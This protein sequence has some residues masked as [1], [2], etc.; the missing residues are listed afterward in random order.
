MTASRKKFIKHRLTKTKYARILCLLTAVFFIAGTC[1]ITTITFSAD[2]VP[3]LI[4]PIVQFIKLA[5][6]PEPKI[7]TPSNI[8]QQSALTRIKLLIG[9]TRNV[10]TI[11]T[12]NSVIIVSPEIASAQ[13]ENGNVLKITGAKIGETMLIITG[14]GKRQ[15]F[16]IEVFWKP[17]VAPRQNSVHAEQA[18]SENAK[19]SGS[20]N[21]SSTKNSEQHLS[22][23]RNRIEFRRK[24]SDDRTLR[25]SGEMYKFFGGDNREKGLSNFQ[26]YGLDR[27]S[28]SIDSPDKTI[29]FLDSS[30]RISPV[31]SNNFD[32][33][34]FH[35]VSAPKLSKNPDSPRK[36]IEVFAG[37]ARPTSVFYDKTRAKLIGALIPVASGVSWQLRA[38]FVS[39]MASKDNQLGR[40]G[41]TF[42]LGGSYSPNKKFSANGEI[43]LANGSLSWGARFNLKLKKFGALT[44]FSRV[45]KDSPL[46]SLNGL[47]GG[48]KTEAFSVYWRPEKR[49]NFSAR[50][51]HTNIE[52][53]TN[54]RFASFN[55]ST[56][57]ANAS[58]STVRNSRFNFRFTDQQIETAAPGNSSKFQIATKTFT[59]G[60]NTRINRY[61][62]NDFEAGINLSSE[63]NAESRL[64]TGFTVREQLRFTWNENSL[65]GFLNYTNKTSSLTSLIMQNPQLLPLE[66]QPVF[67]LDPTQFLQV[68]RDRLA[69]LLPGIE[70]PATRNMDAGVRFQTTVSRFTLTGETRYGANEVY[71]QNQKNLFT[72]I[73][74]NFLLDAA[75]SIQINGWHSFGANSQSG[76]VFGFT[77]R[78]GSGSGGGFQFSKLLGLNK[79]K[80]RGRVFYDLNGN[81]QDDA[82]E[83]GVIGTNVKLNEKRS[84]KTDA[85]GKYE[86]SANEGRY[87]IS[88]VSEELGV[89]LSASTATDRQVAV[90]SR[91]TV[92]VSFG[93]S[94]FGFISGRVFNDANLTDEPAKSNAK[95]I[96]NVR[97]VLHSR[98][99]QS[100]NSIVERVSIN[101]GHYE[102]RN[103]PPGNYTLSIDSLTLPANFRLPAQ[104]SWEIKVLPLQGVYLDIPIM[105]QRAVAGIVF[106]DKDGDGK[107]NPKKDEPVEGAT[108]TVNDSVAVSD[109]N[110]AYILRNLP[111]GRMQAVARTP[112]GLVNSPIFIDLS[113][114]PVTKR[115][116]D[117][118]VALK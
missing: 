78:F 87:N 101:G 95:G 45:D 59:A 38:G 71:S 18:L 2:K 90:S 12:A 79:G 39:V 16:I 54:S 19:M 49:F 97:L 4:K 8:P 77:H 26:N 110:G 40:S 34:G 23:V 17:P 5:A 42:H 20:Y 103:L 31:I 24:L 75:N 98:N 102:F 52:R 64:E 107:F 51:N 15:T 108:V 115:A 36:G 53:T 47:T 9:E 111:A 7:D 91:Q 61:L 1:L 29:D 68:Y 106:I 21:V 60:Y 92:N 33:R 50:Y 27:I 105:A 10:T 85:E 113:A 93:V 6:T 67:A 89:R 118:I 82:G 74:V 66:L 43:A 32:M 69:F 96:N 114:E 25:V 73:G 117:F 70:L 109:R 94:S 30:V 35:L 116:V 22:P 65:T 28:V 57:S 80:V 76:V 56:F 86:F 72:S 88:L 84:V 13:I 11:L 58:Y 63:A 37:L 46:G 55:R 112:S 81:G 14:D 104:T 99:S 83:P 44:E 48:R 100:G 62:S 41:T 3:P